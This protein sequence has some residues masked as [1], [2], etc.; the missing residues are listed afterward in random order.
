M[1]EN[2]VLIQIRE[3]I[4]EKLT[5]FRLEQKSIMTVDDLSAYLDLQPSY[6]RKMTHNKKIPYYKPNEKK[7]YFLREEIDEWVLSSR[8][9]TA[10]ELRS[11][12]KRRVKRL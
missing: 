12:A 5:A 6:I 11:E 10:E 4:D 7:L 3:L 9:A 1:E 8:V 2:S